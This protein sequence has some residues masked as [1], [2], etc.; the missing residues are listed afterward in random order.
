MS[1]E[2]A[3]LQCVPQ[4]FVSIGGLEIRLLSIN[5]NLCQAVEV[6]KYPTPRK[7]VASLVAQW[8]RV[9]LPVQVTWVP[10]LAWEDPTYPG[11]T[12]PMNRRLLSHCA[13]TGG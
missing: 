8:L 10:S 6:A 5:S 12:K 13:P 9:H 11:A 7:A 3:N 2:V 4:R 1:V